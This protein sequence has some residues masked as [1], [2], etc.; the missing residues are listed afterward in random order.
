MP[1]G[2]YL[3]RGG[4][5]GE[6]LWS[7]NHRA[8]ADIAN[9]FCSASNLHLDH[10]CGQFHSNSTKPTT[11]SSLLTSY[12]II[13]LNLWEQSRGDSGRSSGNLSHTTQPA[14]YNRGRVGSI[15][16]GDSTAIRPTINTT[17]LNHPGN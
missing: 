1:K 7:R 4:M 14:L 5:Q 11:L 17:P 15:Q 8:R 2:L 9:Y 10:G 6:T 13:L 3:E 16:E 12:F